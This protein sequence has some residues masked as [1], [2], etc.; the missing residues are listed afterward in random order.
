[1]DRHVSRRTMYASAGI[2]AIAAALWASPVAAT[3]EPPADSATPA[4]SAPASAAPT[5]GEGL[6]ILLTNDDG[7]DGGGLLPLRDALIAAGH[8]VVVFAPAD[9]QSGNSGRMTFG[10]PL[11]IT[12]ETEGVFSV[13]GSPADSSEVG[14]SLA[15]PGAL[16][17]LVISGPNPGANIANTSIHSG[18][19]GAAVTAANDGV[20]AIAVSANGAPG[21]NEV[22]DVATGEFVVSLVDAL[23]ANA[24]GDALLPDGLALNVNLPYVEPGEAFAGVV[25]TTTD[26]S[27]LDLDYAAVELPAVGESVDAAAQFVIVPT[28]DADSDSAA[29]EAG[30]VAI[31][32]V[33]GNYDATADDGVAAELEALTPVLTALAG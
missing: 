31:T 5:A 10:D 21:T 26:R 6:R 18:T 23:A 2:A 19:I 9:D 30:Q 12:Q 17:D 14:M 27:F 33:E 24:A 15:F 11:T 3:T 1:M 20:P 16:P 8:D 29:I 4:S 7:W 32:F 22:D 25:I 28:V 13:A